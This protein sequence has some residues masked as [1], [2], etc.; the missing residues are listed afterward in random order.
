MLLGVDQ[1]DTLRDPL[2]F[3][4]SVAIVLGVVLLAE[5]LFLTGHQW[6]TGAEAAAARRH[7]RRRRRPRQQRRARRPRRCSP[8]S[9]G[10]SRSPPCCSCSPSSARSSSPAAAATPTERRDRGGGRARDA[11]A[12]RVRDHATYYLVL[13]AL[14]FTIGAVGLLTRRNVLVMFMCVE[15][16]LN[17]VNLTFV[18]FARELNDIRGQ[19]IVFF[20][21]VG[22]RGRG[23]G[24]P[25][26]HRRDLPSPARRHRRRPRPPEGLHLVSARDLLDLVWI[27]P[28]LPLLGAV[29][30]LLFG[31]RIGEPLAGWIATGLVALVV[32]RVAR[33]VLRHARPAA[34]GAGEHRHPLHLAAGRAACTSTWASTPTRCRSRGSC[35]SPASAR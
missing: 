3:Q 26:H 32:R 5:I 27:V 17:A 12:R 8:T 29:V 14:L 10:R 25:R 28:A 13:A 2:R 24:R 33:D 30:L 20:M 11:D 34:R 7:P 9:S 16:M 1:P 6:A 23:R 35:S 19:V 22:R 15:L 4:R 21:L 31:K 18:S